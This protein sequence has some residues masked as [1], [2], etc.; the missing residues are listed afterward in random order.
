LHCGHASPWT[1]H[2]KPKPCC[3]VQVYEATSRTGSVATQA[4]GHSRRGAETMQTPG[5]DDQGGVDQACT[6][7]GRGRQRGGRRGGAGRGR[8]EGRGGGGA[9]H[10]AMMVVNINPTHHG[11][12]RAQGGSRP[13][14][15]SEAHTLTGRGKGSEGEGGQTADT[16]AQDQAPPTTGKQ[17]RNGACTAL[18]RRRRRR[19][20]RRRPKMIKVKRSERSSLRASS[21][22]QQ[23][24]GIHTC[25]HTCATAQIL[26]AAMMRWPPK[27]IHTAREAT[28]AH[29]PFAKE[30]RRGASV[31]RQ[32]VQPGIS[33]RQVFLPQVRM[34][35]FPPASLLA[36][37]ITMLTARSLRTPAMPASSLIMIAAICEGCVGARVSACVCASVCV[38]VCGR[39]SRP[40]CQPPR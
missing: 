9:C 6:R 34:S 27:G 38:R 35:K 3:S 26:P 21:N 33:L 1:Q 4:V 24:C 16:E 19:Q 23:M 31:P 20:R 28:P 5:G 11:H 17:Q 39:S 8:V 29:P 15:R 12:F 36:P 22:R 7:E 2:R 18:R 37:S 10:D 14:R 40:P 30:Q 13:R 25:F 32:W